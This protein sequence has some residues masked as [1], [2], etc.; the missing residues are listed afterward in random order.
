MS[1][2]QHVLLYEVPHA[3]SVVPLGDIHMHICIYACMYKC[4]CVYICLHAFIHVCSCVYI[5]HL[6]TCMYVRT[7]IHIYAWKIFY[8]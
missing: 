1:E 5:S 8:E 3:V 2:A 4:I 6:F 7:Y